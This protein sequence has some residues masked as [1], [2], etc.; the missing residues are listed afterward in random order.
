MTICRDTVGAVEGGPVWS[1]FVTVTS[2]GAVVL[3]SMDVV[4]VLNKEESGPS[5][6]EYVN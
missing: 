2:V 4:V 3:D 6:A 5:G 1:R